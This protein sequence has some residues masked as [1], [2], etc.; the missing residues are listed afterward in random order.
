MK[1]IYRKVA[2]FL[3][4]VFVLNNCVGCASTANVSK[5]IPSVSE[6]MSVSEEILTSVSSSD[7]DMPDITSENELV[8]Q[9][10]PV[11]E[12]SVSSA[13]AG[14]ISEDSVSEDTVSEDIVEEKEEQEKEEEEEL[15][16]VTNMIIDTDMGS[17]ADDAA[18]VRVAT[19]MAKMGRVNLL[20]VMSSAT[21][22]DYPM[23]CHALL[24]YDG[25]PDVPIGYTTHECELDAVYTY[26]ISI[27]Y[28][29]EAS[30]R[31]AE[32]TELYK[33][34]LRDLKSRNETCTIV[35]LGFLVNIDML[36]HDPEGYELVRDVV[37]CIWFDGGVYP[38]R[39]TDFNFCWRGN[40][41]GAAMYVTDN[42]PCPVIYVTNSTGTT[43]EYDVIKCGRSFPEL[44]PYNVDPVHIAYNAMENDTTVED[45]FP[46]LAGDPDLKKDLSK[47]HFAYDAITVFGG[48]LTTSEDTAM[49]KAKTLPKGQTQIPLMESQLLLQPIEA[50]I[51]ENGCN[52]FFPVSSQ[53]N[54]YM[55]FRQIYELDWYEDQMDYWINMGIK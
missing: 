41:T 12:T 18:A 10:I 42:C 8:I 36:I 47:G 52:E 37:D 31:L 9:E 7:I 45:M 33:A 30:Y 24:C 51:Y 48:A 2:S 16:T 43:E 17:D 27:P 19:Q 22:K 49:L 40:V 28:F 25:F 20:A 26:G 11:M 50:H 53:S 55:V 54:R 46:E 13:S 14:S 1:Q 38:G 3:L 6:D 34:V 32:S 15:P 39:G 44:D 21:T 4:F 5:T 29:D 23:C 35:V